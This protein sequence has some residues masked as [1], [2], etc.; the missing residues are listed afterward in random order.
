MRISVIVLC[1]LTTAMCLSCRGKEQEPATTLTR[2][3]A[4]L[5]R[6]DAKALISAWY[7][8]KCE[9]SFRAEPEALSG[10]LV[11]VE[12]LGVAQE[13][14]QTLVKA[15]AQVMERKT[16]RRLCEAY[17]MKFELRKYDSGWQVE[18]MTP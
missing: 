10:A 1:F 5:T 14:N 13:G 4:K 7:R 12:I 9:S 6:E 18:G 2:E 3:D 11:K 16:G 15:N 8:S 17:S